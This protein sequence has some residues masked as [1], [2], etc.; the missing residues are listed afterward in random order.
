ML[1]PQ[2][3]L[4]VNATLINMRDFTNE[5]GIYLIKLTVG[6]ETQTARFTLI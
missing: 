6:N 3:A 1:Y 5:K 4:G 2:L